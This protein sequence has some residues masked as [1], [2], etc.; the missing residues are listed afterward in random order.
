MQKEH[1]RLTD[2]L[3]TLRREAREAESLIREL[4]SKYN[5]NTRVIDNLEDENNQL[6][7]QVEDIHDKSISHINESKNQEKEVERLRKVYEQKV[8]L[9]KEKERELERLRSEIEE[10]IA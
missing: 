6:K 3:D 7:A 1:K 10:K 9:L 2:E 4:S 8:A 5:E